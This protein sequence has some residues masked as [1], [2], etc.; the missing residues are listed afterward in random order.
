M[1]NNTKKENKDTVFTGYS[2]IDD[3]FGGLKPREV[4]II[5]GRPAM[6]KTT[7]A[8][9]IALHAAS[10]ENKKVLFISDENS[11]DV[12]EQKLT[13]LI[14]GIPRQK[15]RTFSLSDAEWDSCRNTIQ[16]RQNL[17]IYFCPY[18]IVQ[19]VSQIR[20]V[21]KYFAKAE[22]LD[23][24]IIDYLQLVT[25]DTGKENN[26]EEKLR[27]IQK[28]A[29][30]FNVPVV[31]LTQLSRTLEERKDKRP[32]RKDLTRTGITKDC[33]DQ[34][35]LLYR[36]RYYYSDAPEND[37]ELIGIGHD[38]K[39]TG[40]LFWDPEIGAFQNMLVLGIH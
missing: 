34:A 33:F 6:G 21:C 12:M 16:Y 24:V 29:R 1:E 40:K 17:P 31:V 23:L 35:F 7:L 14:S 36:D 39:C 15:L 28:I 32:K 9:N 26:T 3:T 4:T 22:K 37:A 20:E 13:S 10:K 5:G 18:Q 25:E 30:K 8:L 27:I 11:L 19:T 38:T 2:L